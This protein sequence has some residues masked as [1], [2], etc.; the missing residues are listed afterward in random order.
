MTFTPKNWL[1]SPNTTTPLNAA[2]MVDIE[3]RL[4]AYTDA[5][6][7][8]SVKQ[9]GA[10]G[11]GTTDDTT[12]LN[13]C[14]VAA[15]GGDIYIPSGT[16]KISAP[17]VIYGGTRLTLSLSATITLAAGSD[18]NMLQNQA[19]VGTTPVRDVNIEVRGGTW[20]RG[21]DGGGATPRNRNSLVFRRVDGLIVENL[22]VTSSAGKFAINPGDVTNF[23][24][25]DIQ[26][27]VSSDGVHVNGP[28]TNGTIDGVYGTCGDDITALVTDDFAGYN[29]VTGSISNVSIRG[30]FASTAAGAVKI[31]GSAGTG[32][33]RRISISDIICSATS[34]GVILMGDGTVAGGGAV[35]VGDVTIDNVSVVSNGSQVYISTPNARSIYLRNI[36]PPSAAG[37]SAVKVASAS[38]GNAVVEYLSI[39]NVSITKNVQNAV[40]LGSNATINLLS[41]TG[42]NASGTN[43]SA[44]GLYIDSTSTVRR[45]SI[46]GVTMNRGGDGS[47]VLYLNGG[48]TTTSVFTVSDV[49]MYGGGRVL[50]TTSGAGASVIAISNVVGNQMFDLASIATAVELSLENVNIDASDTGAL[51][52]LTGAGAS[53]VLRGSGA[54]GNPQGRAGVSRDSTQT[55]RIIAGQYPADLS[56]LAKNNGDAANNTNGGLACGLGPATSNG[57]NWKNVYTGSVY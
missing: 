42:M 8:I 36:K 30:V 1:N 39:D 45:G 27:A 6:D 26:L 54:I 15:K 57:S 14:L 34:W 38:A 7:F 32:T 43:T 56:I 50:R 28:A 47:A 11:D 20:A 24:I 17:L 40:E 41:I 44:Y 4:A 18:C 5:H 48:P 19:V 35:D 12:A 3:T 46:R 55:I 51:I 33:V 37:G 21:A 22:T 29:D 23:A 31:T 10:T 53:L 49:V 2:A 25:R 9:Y 13:A 16:Y 52:K